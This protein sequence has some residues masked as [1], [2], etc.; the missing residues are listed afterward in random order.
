ME[1][2]IRWIHRF[3]NYRKALSR[4]TEAVELSRERDLSDLEQQGLIQAFEFTYE[5]AWKTLKDIIIEGRVFERS[6]GPNVIIPIALEEGL[7]H[8]EDE[9]EEMMKAR[10]LTTHAYE[11]EM[12]NAMAT[13]IISKFQ[14]MFIQLETRLQ[15]EKLNREKEL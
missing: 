14:G 3:S 9:W 1:N 6:P 10:I 15:I 13:L 2:D 7:I 4:L 5:L 8:G 12:A 11:E